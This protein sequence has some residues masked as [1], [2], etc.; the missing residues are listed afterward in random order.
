MV[1]KR[2]TSMERESPCNAHF[3]ESVPGVGDAMLGTVDVFYG[4]KDR[5]DQAPEGVQK[6]VK[7]FAGVCVL[8]AIMAGCASAPNGA[9]GDGVEQAP[10]TPLSAAT[11]A[12]LA[13]TLPKNS[14]EA[15]GYV[16]EEGLRTAAFAGGFV[17]AAAL[18][19][20]NAAK[21][22]H[23]AEC[24]ERALDA[25]EV[26]IAAGGGTVQHEG[27]EV[28]GVFAVALL[29]QAAWNDV[30]QGVSIDEWSPAHR[31]TRELPAWAQIL[32][33]VSG[34]LS[35]LAERTYSEDAREADALFTFAKEFGVGY[36]VGAEAG[37]KVVVEVRYEASLPVEVSPLVGGVE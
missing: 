11:A 30:L 35:T 12:A 8:S 22:H 26:A 13:D 10:P 15:A 20:L 36:T 27:T 7:G 17:G 18:E 25:L 24:A 31:N 1:E 32:Q 14:A 34:P 5:I 4:E 16:V 29:P 23:N 19:T 28:R 6:R 33:T 2:Y 21:I 9:S 3:M 37:E